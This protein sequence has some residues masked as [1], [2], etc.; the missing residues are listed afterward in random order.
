V[1]SHVVLAREFLAAD[2][3]RVS[4]ITKVSLTSMG[5][6]VPFLPEALPAD[7][8]RKGLLLSVGS[9]MV[10]KFRK[11]GEFFVAS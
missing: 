10:V 5:N 7:L 3:A 8:A 9:D 6:E 1:L 4:F 11:I 2:A